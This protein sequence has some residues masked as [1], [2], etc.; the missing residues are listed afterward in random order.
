MSCYQVVGYYKVH[1]IASTVTSGSYAVE[2][3]VLYNGELYEVVGTGTVS[4]TG[5][6]VFD[7]VFANRSVSEIIFSD[8]VVNIQGFQNCK[9]VTS[10]TISKNTENIIMYAFAYC[11]NLKTINFDGTKS[12]W[13]AISKGT[14]WKVG[15]STITVR[16]SNGN[17][18]V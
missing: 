5:Q 17:I 3:V 2:D 7:T 15:C 14:N 13:N 11:T 1:L 16:C 8:S 18:T 4:S 10:V 9:T 6:I 12:E